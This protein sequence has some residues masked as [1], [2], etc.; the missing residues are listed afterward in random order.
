MLDVI[1]EAYC[2]GCIMEGVSRR[3]CVR[4]WVYHGGCV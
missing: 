1:E 4:D 3:V 2:R